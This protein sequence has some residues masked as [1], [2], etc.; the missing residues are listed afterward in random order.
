MSR[1]KYFQVS[2]H[3]RFNTTRTKKRKLPSTEI[4]LSESMLY[5]KN[6]V[7]WDVSP[8][9]SCKNRRFGR[10]F[11]RSYRRENR[12]FYMLYPFKFYL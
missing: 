11:L 12:N 10:N 6:T 7:F 8:C 4:A 3:D 1:R 2:K 9:G 5:Q